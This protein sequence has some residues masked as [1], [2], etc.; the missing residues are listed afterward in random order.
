MGLGYSGPF[1]SQANPQSFL[2][3]HSPLGW[4]IG[5]FHGHRAYKYI[6][7]VMK[8]EKNLGNVGCLVGW[9]LAG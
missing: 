8:I 3:V 6:I 7:C 2:V 4:L 5:W 9:G 1:F